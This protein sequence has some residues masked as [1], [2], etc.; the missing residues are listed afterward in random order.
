MTPR[1]S[2]LNRQARQERQGDNFK[3]NKQMDNRITMPES[4]RLPLLLSGKK[5]GNVVA[6]PGALWVQLLSL[7]FLAALGVPGQAWLIL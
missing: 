7:F 6:L 4:I 5:M 3:I 1:R 2:I